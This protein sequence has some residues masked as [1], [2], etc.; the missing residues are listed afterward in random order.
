MA[1]RPGAG[2]VLLIALILGLLTAYLAWNYLRGVEKQSAANYKPVVV[3]VV[4]IAPRT[5]VTRDM[6]TMSRFPEENLAPNYLTKLE[7][8]EGKMAKD[9][10]KAKDQL[11]ETD[12]IKEGQAPSL[13]YEIP[14]GKRAV[15]IGV[16]EVRGVGASIQPGDHVDI[17]ATYTDPVARQETTQMILQNIPVLAVDRGRTQA[18][19]KQGGASTSITLAVSP[20]EVELVTA[21]D[22]AGVLRVSLRPVKDDTIVASSGTRVSEILR[23]QKF[24][25]NMSTPRTGTNDE[26]RLTPIII[27]PPPKNEQQ[28][29]K[30]YRGTTETTIRPE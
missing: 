7:D 17:L 25:E 24:F 10:I 23:G 29:I 1:K 16:D 9:K 26:V 15:A 19:A 2:G 5:V 21:A 12:L 28:E 27:S 6:I 4:D 11:R 20:E 8:A 18:D 14:K 13:T 30:I 22:R 3:A